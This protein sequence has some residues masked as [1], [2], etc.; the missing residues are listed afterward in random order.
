MSLEFFGKL[1]VAN[2]LSHLRSDVIKRLFTTLVDQRLGAISRRCD[3]DKA[4]PFLG[5]GIACRPVVP[6]LNCTTINAIC[7]DDPVSIARALEAL[8]EEVSLE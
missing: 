5:A 6:D 7:K 2:T 1:T 8:L 4:G 3:G